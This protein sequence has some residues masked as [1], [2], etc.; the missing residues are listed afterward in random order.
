MASDESGPTTS[1]CSMLGTR[2][3]VLP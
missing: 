2:A 3:T 1:T